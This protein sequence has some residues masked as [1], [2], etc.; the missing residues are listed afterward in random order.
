MAACT[1]CP[2]CSGFVWLFHHLWESIRKNVAFLTPFQCNS[3]DLSS[4]QVSKAPASIWGQSMV[5]TTG[6]IRCPVLGVGALFFKVWEVDGRVKYLSNAYIYI[7]A[8]LVL[9]S[10][11]SVLLH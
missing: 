10:D 1:E 4:F 6:A 7:S 2:W 8:A 5:A 9:L 11:F 3:L